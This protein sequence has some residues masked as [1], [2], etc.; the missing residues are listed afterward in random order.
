VYV[1]YN[2]LRWFMRIKIVYGILYTSVYTSNRD[3]TGVM[4]KSDEVNRL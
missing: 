3:V 4:M 1:V 2:V